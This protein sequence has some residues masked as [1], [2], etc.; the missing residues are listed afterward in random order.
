MNDSGPSP[1]VP[2]SDGLRTRAEALLKARSP[3]ADAP[4]GD[5]G[6]TERMLHELQVHHVEL[7]L[8]NEELESARREAEAARDR[9]ARIFDLA[10]GGVLVL[11]RDGVI[12]DAN[13]TATHLLQSHKTRLLGRRL[14]DFVDDDSLADLTVLL[15]NADPQV[16]PRADLGLRD[17]AQRALRVQAVCASDP[18]AQEL[19]MTLTDISERERLKALQRSA[20]QALEDA[21]RMKSEFLSRMSHELRTPLNAVLGFAHLQQ[22]DDRHPLDA[23]N[24]ERAGY[25][26]QAGQHLQTLIE[27]SLDLAAIEA[28]RVKVTL[29][30]V[31]MAPLLHSCMALVE[32]QAEAARVGVRADFGAATAGVVLA[33]A[34]RLRQVLLNLMTNAIKYNRPGGELHLDSRLDAATDQVEIVVSDNGRGMTPVQQQR[35]FHP[36]DRLGAE[37]TGIPGTGLGLMITRLL[38]VAMGGELHIESKAGAGT[39]ARV[40]LPAATAMASAAPGAGAHAALPSGSAPG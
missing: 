24:R 27:E 33:D 23:K 31:P 4:E 21:D 13:A 10:P 40:L 19:L 5:V 30:P 15:S 38:V 26:Q 20:L 39:R 12:L 17:A 29:S 2:P 37:Q 25:I 11:G 18:H 28:G 36:F 3:P 34:Q 22:I 32:F 1:A 8:Q 14:T 16:Q 35:L 9:F 6:D 7:Q